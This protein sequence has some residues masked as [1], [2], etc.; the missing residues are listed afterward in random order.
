MHITNVGQGDLDMELNLKNKLIVWASTHN[1]NWLINFHNHVRGLLKDQLKDLE[2][3]KT[4]DIENK[5]HKQALYDY[6]RMLHINTL[7]MMYSYLEEWLYHCWK[8]YVP[9]KVGLV[10]RKG[11]LGRFKKVAKQLGIDLSSRLWEDLINAEEIRNCLLHA[12]GRISLLKDPKKDKVKKIIERKNSGLEIIKDRIVIS[13][14]YLQRFNESICK[15]LDIMIK[16][17]AQHQL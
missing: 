11:S 7:L 8:I 15:L 9:K 14:D 13:S 17:G 6:D 12:N 3:A 2:A 16:C 5:L 4:K 10:K 1:L